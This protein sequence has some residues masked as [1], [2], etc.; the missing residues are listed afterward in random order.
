MKPIWEAWAIQL[1]IT[2]FCNLSCIYCS[3]YNKHLRNDQRY[4]MELGYFEKVIQSLEEWKGI[5]GIIGGEPLLH[6]KF[7][8]ICEIMRKYF[9]KTK[10]QLFTSHKENFK[11]YKPIL[12]ETF[13]YFAYNE[14][15]DA[16][17]ELCKFQ[18]LTIAIGEVIKNEKLK[19][20]LI[21]DCWVQK[22]WCPAVN[23]KGGFFCEVAAA[24]DVIL[25]GPGGYD[26][27]DK[28]WWKKAPEAFKDQADRYCNLCGMAIPIERELIKNIK[29]KFTPELYNKFVQN[30]QKHMDN[31]TVEIFDRILSDKE[32][33]EKLYSGEWQPWKNRGDLPNGEA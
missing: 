17:K 29:E 3:R 26:I 15:N 11:K 32:V 20:Q 16:Q 19:A 2:N 12:D 25:D 6:P 27:N 8:E 33:L 30:G 13:E 21:D 7:P 14:H 24:L 4:F 18:P 23:N 31:N 1:D 10:Y 5:I 28:N 22:K 9:P